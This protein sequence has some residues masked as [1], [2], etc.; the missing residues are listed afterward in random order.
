MHKTL[1][2]IVSNHAKESKERQRLEASTSRA[3][4]SIEG[5]KNELKKQLNAIGNNLE[6]V[7]NS[8]K[9]RAGTLAITNATKNFQNE[10]H[11]VNEK[12]RVV[13]EENSH[14]K[15]QMEEIKSQ[16]QHLAACV[17]QV[18][19]PLAGEELVVEKVADNNAN[20]LELDGG[21]SSA[22]TVSTT[23]TSTVCSLL[24]NSTSSTFFVSNAASSLMRSRTDFDEESNAS[25]IEILEDCGDIME[26]DV[27]D[28][29]E[30]DAQVNGGASLYP[31]DMEV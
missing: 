9:Q 2:E 22:N 20:G 13:M 3:M 30:V 27:V 31:A 10:L 17:K 14:L 8:V 16:L 21:T 18:K 19:L 28:R 12:M 15:K 6:Q 5:E 7:S 11:N 24:S 1:E 23:D 4:R 25:G 29:S 26:F